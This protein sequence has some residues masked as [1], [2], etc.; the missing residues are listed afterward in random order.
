MYATMGN[1]K[2]RKKII[3][4]VADTCKNPYFWCLP[5]RLNRIMQKKWLKDF[6]FHINSSTWS[7]AQD[8]LQAG[9]VKN[10]REVERHFWVAQVETVERCFETEMIITPQKIKA[11][12]CEC[13]TEGR[14]LI[15]AHIAASLV[16]VRQ[17]LDHR[18]EEKKLQQLQPEHT[19][20]SRLTVQTALENAT[21]EALESFVRNY[22]KRDRDFALALKTW[23]ASSI[24]TTEN[25]YALVLAA[26]F[27]KNNMV[28]TLREPDFR[29]IRKTLEDLE[30]QLMAAATQQN[31]RISF[32]LASTILEYLLP[33]LA[34]L[35]E[36]R[37]DLLL[38]FAQTA[39]VQLLSVNEAAV[40][41]ELRTLLWDTL[42]DFGAKGLYQPAMLRE[43]IRFLSAQADNTHRFEQMQQLFDATPLPAEAFPLQLFLVALARKDM[44]L[45]VV[46]VLDDYTEHPKVIREATLQLYYLQ[47]W[48]A[49]T[50][51]IE[52]FIPLRIF[53]TGQRRELED[54][55]Y[56]IAEKTGDWDR[57]NNIL[58]ERFVAT[59]Q[60]EF[61]NKLKSNTLDKWPD[62]LELILNELHLKNDHRTI[63]A[64]LAAEGNLTALAAQL[65]MHDDWTVLQRYEDLF[66]PEDNAFLAAL[67]TRL[68][69]TYLLDH[70]GRQASG[71]VRERLGPLAAKGHRTLVKEIIA[72]LCIQFEERTTLSEEL[73]ELFPKSKRKDVPS[74]GF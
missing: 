71:F 20:R 64:V 22:A 43:S 47:H 34:K 48:D 6:E 52:H 8:L 57:Q 3:V 72:A 31:H 2:N 62:V 38:P 67:Y 21:P 14:Q 44:P 53:S 9:Q 15:C 28:K 16:K 66:I 33:L 56:F 27:P 13:F 51:L 60:F 5:A 61:Y 54:I 63:A 41:P 30:L 49:V 12:S 24:T 39:L 69:S 68:L 19:E 7:T 1:S 23:F 58:R 40:S 59:G 65:E 45:A 18:A 32:R 42:F 25:P 4:L 36:N 74:L 17:F 50:A 35:E 73:M 46:R 29:R 37:R 10:L 11:F 70:F 26:V 55:L